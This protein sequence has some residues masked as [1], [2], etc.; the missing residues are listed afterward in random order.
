M[1]PVQE[2]LGQ[3]DGQGASGHQVLCKATLDVCAPSVK[4]AGAGWFLG[5]L[6]P[7]PYHCACVPGEQRAYGAVSVTLD[8]MSG[9]QALVLCPRLQIQ[10]TTD[11]LS[12]MQTPEDF[13]TSWSLSPMHPT[14]R[15]RDL[16]PETNRR[17]SFKGASG[18][19]DTQKVAQSCWSTRRWP[20]ELH[21]TL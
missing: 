15:S 19:W 5:Y 1:P 7:S 17:S 14:Q 4:G 8:R 20:I 6:L 2:G 13:F 3:S 10:E 16:D 11:E 12:P 21:L 9:Q 18:P